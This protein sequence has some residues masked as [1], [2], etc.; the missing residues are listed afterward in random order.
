[1]SQQEATG[2]KRTCSIAFGGAAV[3]AVGMLAAVPVVIAV[4]LL[5]CWGAGFIGLIT[6]VETA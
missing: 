3:A 2:L 4:G 1:M 6:V 5:V